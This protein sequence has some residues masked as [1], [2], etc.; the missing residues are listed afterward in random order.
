MAKQ[1]RMRPSWKKDSRRAIRRELE[2]DRISMPVIMTEKEFDVFINEI[3][4]PTGLE[5]V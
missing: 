4:C 1:A 2:L 5:D 3:L